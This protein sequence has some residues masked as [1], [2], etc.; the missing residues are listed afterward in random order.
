MDSARIEEEYRQWGDNIARYISSLSG[1]KE[2]YEDAIQE[3]WAKACAYNGPVKDFLP[4]MLVVARN[5]LYGAYRSNARVGEPIQVDWS[6]IQDSRPG[7]AYLYEEK[8]V[9]ESI[10][11]LDCW[12]LLYSFYWEGLSVRE[13]AQAQ[14]VQDHIVRGQLYRARAKL[15]SLLLGEGRHW[16]V[17]SLYNRYHREEA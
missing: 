3:A 6:I 17:D 8:A 9:D 5:S 1:R 11:S 4:W 7:P 16:K 14:G 12:P 15:E 10:R 2:D 13:I